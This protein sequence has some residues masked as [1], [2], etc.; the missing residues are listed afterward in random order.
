VKSIDLFLMDF[1]REIARHKEVTNFM[2]FGS[3]AN[4][5]WNLSSHVD[6]VICLE[7][8]RT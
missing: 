1:M 3:A 5:N 2:L 8:L 7:R 6:V 4:G